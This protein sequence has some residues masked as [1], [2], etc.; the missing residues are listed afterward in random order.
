MRKGM[1]V[2]VLSNKGA[3]G[4]AYQQSIPAGYASDTQLTEILTCAMV[5]ADSNGNIEVP[6][7]RGLPRVYYPTDG[8]SGSGLCGSSS[9]L[10]RSDA[11]A[12]A[13]LKIVPE[14]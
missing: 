2:T 4:D 11:D 13:T 9:K 8:L 5:T 6:M 1:M 12:D 14:L 7:A 3:S 10:K